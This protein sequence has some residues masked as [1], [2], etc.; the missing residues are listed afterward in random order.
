MANEQQGNQLN[1]TV[2]QLQSALHQEAVRQQ[3]ARSKS[4]FDALVKEETESLKHLD[5]DEGYVER[6]PLAEAFKDP[7]LVRAFEAR[8]Y[9]TPNPIQRAELESQILAYSQT[10]MAR[11]SMLAD[12]QQRA[13]A[14][15]HIQAEVLRLYESTFPDPVTYRRNGA[16][17][18]QQATEQMRPKTKGRP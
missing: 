1:Q 12:P 10:M 18:V 7:E 2:Q 13:L 14:Q 4:D 3:M 17:Y 8:Y 5:L 11:A 16:K 15:R 6:C 9:E